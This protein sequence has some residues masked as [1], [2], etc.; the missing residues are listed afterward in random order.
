MKRPWPGDENRLQKALPLSE[1]DDVGKL[2]TAT[3][4]ETRDDGLHHAVQFGGELEFRL[5]ALSGI[6]GFIQMSRLFFKIPGEVRRLGFAGLVTLVGTKGCFDPAV[7][8]VWIP[9][10][11][12]PVRIRHEPRKRGFSEGESLVRCQ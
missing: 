7:E 10:A 3:Q 8:T 4:A 9:R 5:R 2:K 12:N 6:G 11:V 1:L